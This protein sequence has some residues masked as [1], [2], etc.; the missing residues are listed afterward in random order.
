[1]SLFHFPPAHAARPEMAAALCHRITSRSQSHETSSTTFEA[2]RHLSHANSFLSTP[3]NTLKFRLTSS[4]RRLSELT[5]RKVNAVVAD[6]TQ[7][8]ETG[9][10]FAES[11]A[12]EEV[13][14]VGGGVAG[15]ATA[16]ALHR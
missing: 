12:I 8:R 2:V 6:R 13:V 5:S 4:P 7:D 9:A 11:D 3:L 15:L 1:M 14:I 10:D 16:L